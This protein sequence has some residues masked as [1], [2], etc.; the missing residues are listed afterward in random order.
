MRMPTRSGSCAPIK[1]ECLNRV[2]P[3]GERHLRRTMVE[4]VEHDHG[5]RNHQG[6]KNELIDG[7]PIGERV[8]RIRRR[9]RLGGLLNYYHYTGAA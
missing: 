2:I 4:Y 7:T 9:Q 8:G 5:A 3:F 6:L 1:E